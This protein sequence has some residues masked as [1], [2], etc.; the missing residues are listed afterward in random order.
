MEITSYVSTP[1]GE[2]VNVINKRP[3]DLVDL[4]RTARHDRKAEREALGRFRRQSAACLRRLSSAGDAGDWL[5]AAH[6]LDMSAKS[7]GA[8]ELAQTAR[9]AA[10]LRGAPH[11]GA[12]AALLNTLEAQVSDANA[13]I[14]EI[15]KRA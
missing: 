1:F 4:S 15:L 13:F 3:L 5:D 10:R 12:C 11:G 9:A 8:W 2:G 14:A 6:A 7:V